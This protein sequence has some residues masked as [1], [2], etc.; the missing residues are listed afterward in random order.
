MWISECGVFKCFSQFD[1]PLSE[2]P[3]SFFEIIP[4]H[5]RHS[6]AHRGFTYLN[7]G[8]RNPH[9]VLR[10]QMGHEARITVPFPFVDSTEKDPPDCSARSLMLARPNPLPR[11]S[12]ERVS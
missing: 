4:F 5:I 8:F 6:F 2:A 12:T 7:S 3:C 10:N 1:D 11:P 9:S